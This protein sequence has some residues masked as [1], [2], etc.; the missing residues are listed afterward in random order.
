MV[1]PRL[2]D[3]RT[4]NPMRWDD[5]QLLALIDSLEEAEPAYLNS[6][7]TLFQKATDDRP[8]GSDGAERDFVRELLLAANA[9]LLTWIDNQ[10]AGNVRRPDPLSES[11]RWL[12]EVRDVRLTV[13]GRDRARGRV[14]V[15]PLP[16]PDEDDDRPITGMVL[17]EIARAIGDTYTGSQLPRFLLDAGIPEASIPPSV[18]GSKWEYVFAVLE[19]LHDGG[20][21]SRRELRQFIGG[22][23]S[24]L[25]HT[26]PDAGVQKRIVALLAQQGWHIREGRLV[27]GPRTGDALG[28]LTPVARDAQLAILHADVR[29]VATRYLESG[30]ME[31]A[32]FEAFKAINNRVKA[33]TGLDLDGSPLMGRAFADSNAPLVL[34]D[35][36]TE[37]GRSIQA[38]FRFLF[39]GAVQGIRN[40]DAHEQFKPLDDGEAFEMLTFASMLMRRLDEA[41]TTS[42][43]P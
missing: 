19:Q 14:V 17:E 31:V 37:T 33:M 38:G 32:I 25:H 36:S 8:P 35:L 41:R 21:A 22:W 13:A 4:Y 42:S 1:L 24:G 5:L 7:Y 12:Q 29:E 30:H 18:V 9:G 20:S 2:R 28:A 34:A 10:P 23:L 43:S 26:P 11:Q 3:M 27:I 40:P 16:D 6:A 15:R 39:M